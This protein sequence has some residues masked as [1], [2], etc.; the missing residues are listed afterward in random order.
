MKSAYQLALEQHLRDRGDEE[1]T[2]RIVRSA[3]RLMTAV[4][5]REV[6]ES[7]HLRTGTVLFAP[8]GFYYSMFHMALALLHLDP[9]TEA[10][11]LRRVRHDPLR[12]LVEQRLI[13]NGVLLRAFLD[14]LGELRDLRET[15]NYV[16]G[17]KHAADLIDFKTTVPGLYD[18]TG[19]QFDPAAQHIRAVQESAEAA[20][21]RPSLIA[22]AVGDGLGNDAYRNYLS[23]ED[24]ERVEKYLLSQGLTT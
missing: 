15:A 23:R 6:A 16:F 17:G 3:R 9:N 22:I 21:N 13:A 8:I 14:L 4:T 20:F 12:R 2:A 19:A 11:E 24:E 5:F 7:T 1:W 18:R 10:A